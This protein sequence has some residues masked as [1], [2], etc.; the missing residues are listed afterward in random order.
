M[1]SEGY[2]SWVCLS[3]C[4]CFNSP[5]D[6]LFVP[7]TIPSTSRVMTIS[8]IEPFFSEYA[9][10]QRYERCQHSTSRPFLLCGKRACALFPPR[11][12]SRLFSRW[13]G[14]RHL[15]A[16]AIMSLSKVCQQCQASVPLLITCVSK[17]RI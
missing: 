15:D 8:L 9:P 11:G 5:L 4:P 12:G 13:R 10:L 17:S 3:V 7:K 16:L 14:R 2:C 6:C 1:C